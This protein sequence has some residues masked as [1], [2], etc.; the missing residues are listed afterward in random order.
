M[1]GMHFTRFF[2][3]DFHEISFIIRFLDSCGVCY[4][5]NT[6]KAKNSLKDCGGACGK[7]T[8]N[9]TCGNCIR[10]GDTRNY[11]DCNG[12]CFGRAKINKCGFCVGG[13]T[14]R[15]KNHGEWLLVF[16]ASLLFT[17]ALSDISARWKDICEL[18]NIIWKFAEKKI[19][20]EDEK[21][22]RKNQFPVELFYNYH[23]RHVS[24]FTILELNH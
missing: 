14:G 24:E 15:D 2:F 1:P 20:N 17:V 8:S 12:D 6:G 13:K 11:T 5:G 4:G 23:F 22:R 9:T 10:I 19:E 3:F 16:A 18:N 7:F 21:W